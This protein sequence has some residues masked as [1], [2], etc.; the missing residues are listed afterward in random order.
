MQIGNMGDAQSVK[1]FESGGPHTPQPFHRQRIE[2]GL[3]R[4]GLDDLDTEAC[5]DPVWFGHRFGFDRRQLCEEL[6]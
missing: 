4:S 2:K 1:A 3:L 5:F 6:V